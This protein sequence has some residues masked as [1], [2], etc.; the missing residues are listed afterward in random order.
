MLSPPSASFSVAKDRTGF[1]RTVDFP[2]GLPPEFLSPADFEKVQHGNRIFQAALKIINWLHTRRI[3]WVLENPATSKCWL[4]PGLKKLE[5]SSRCVAFFTDF[6]QFGAA[7]RRSTKF[8]SGNLD[9]QDVER[10][11]RLC[12]GQGCCSRTQRAHFQL[13]GSNHQGIPWVQLAQQFPRSLCKHLAFALTA[14]THYL[15]TSSL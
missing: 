2:W 1:S 14:P 8:L 3:P 6:C 7:W 5:A 10:V 13:T 4:L 15:P 9:A 11:C 12:S